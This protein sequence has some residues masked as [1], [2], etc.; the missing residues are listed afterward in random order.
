MILSKDNLKNINVQG[1]LM[2]GEK[3]FALPEKVMQ[4]GTGVLLR[5]LPDYHIDK[6][7]RAGIFNG[8]IVV[9]KSTGN[10]P[11]AEFDEQD[12][13][14]TMYLKGIA[15][16]RE[17]N[18]QVICSAISRV[19]FADENWN[20]I[21]KVARSPELEII[22]S[23]TTEIG[24][25]LLK[26]EIHKQTPASFPGK[27]LAVL[28]ERF[29]AFNGTPKSGLIIIP[30]E[31]VVDNGN[32]LKAIVL[33]LAHINHLE[34]GFI[35]WLEKHNTFCNSLVDR[36]VPGKPSNE[37]LLEGERGYED[38]IAVMSEVYG[39][40]AIEGDEKVVA[41]LSFSRADPGVI[42]R[43]NIELFRELKLRLLNGAHTLSCAFAIT[44]GLKTVNEAMNNQLFT[45][46]I[47]NL[48]FNE[49][50][51]AIPYKIEPAVATDFAAKVLDRFR[52]PHIHHAWLSI[53]V[54]YT[55]KMKMRVIPLL[56]H[57]Y[58]HND[59]APQL[60]ALGFAAYIRF[61][62]VEKQAD[63]NFTGSVSGCNYTITDS[64]AEYFSI[65]WA[66]GHPLKAT[67][68]I[69]SNRELWD[70]DLTLLP[71][72]QEAVSESLINIIAGRTTLPVRA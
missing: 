3:I 70:V 46:F 50:M 68:E 22:I 13:L 23:N 24:I 30:T 12:G 34:F 16:N 59:Q 40:W 43:P 66:G 11:A 33:E 14:Y 26:E 49:I 35:E 55:T 48:M 28:Y 15:G 21:L 39:L 60:M 45:T 58:K 5:G 19:L 47:T 1:L 56:L 6:A 10:G 52:N 37:N 61:M 44:C 65:A 64:H 2:P 57:H 32:L 51:P 4:F 62:K 72:F 20:A 53:S 42:I 54:Q 38:N 17:V 27:L 67:A 31:L 69:L 29:K 9:V 8:R 36:I 71:G 41:A 18:E 63:G 7:N 25:K